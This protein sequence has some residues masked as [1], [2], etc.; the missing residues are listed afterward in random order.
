MVTLSAFKYQKGLQK[1]VKGDSFKITL[2]N[3]VQRDFLG[4][5]RL[6]TMPS[7]VKSHQNPIKNQWPKPSQGRQKGKAKERPKFAQPAGTKKGKGLVP[8]V[9]GFRV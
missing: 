9:V 8:L 4:V 6:P 2:Y 1:E 3:F 5:P 7:I